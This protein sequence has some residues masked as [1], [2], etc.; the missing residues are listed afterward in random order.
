MTKKTI[1]CIKCGKP[2]VHWKGYVIRI[3]GYGSESKSVKTLAGFCEEHAE[4]GS[5]CGCYGY[6]NLGKMGNC[7]YATKQDNEI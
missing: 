7:I 6:Y 4:L 1:N 2:A 5:T 3:V